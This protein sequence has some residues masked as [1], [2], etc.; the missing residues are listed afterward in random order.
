MGVDKQPSHTSPA[1]TLAGKIPPPYLPARTHGRTSLDSYKFSP[2]P[3]STQLQRFSQF[4]YGTHSRRMTLLP[5]LIHFAA[6]N[7]KALSRIVSDF[8]LVLTFSP[9]ASA[10]S[11]TLSVLLLPLLFSSKTRL[12]CRM[13]R[14]GRNQFGGNTYRCLYWQR[15]PRSSSMPDV[16]R[17]PSSVPLNSS[18]LNAAKLT[19]L[20]RLLLRQRPPRKFQFTS[21]SLESV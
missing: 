8:P 14:S 1:H 18:Q 16:S 12:T 17:L 19:M 21:P 11:S 20:Q 2:L 13:D 3:S 6:V 9:P 5:S 7:S 10:C 15:V 4:I